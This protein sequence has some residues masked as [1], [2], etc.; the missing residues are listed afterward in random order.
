MANTDAQVGWRLMKAPGIFLN[1]TTGR[2]WQ[3]R[4]AWLP[5]TLGDALILST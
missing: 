2:S 3:E 1:P 4:L 5:C